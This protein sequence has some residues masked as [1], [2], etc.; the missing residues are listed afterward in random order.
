MTLKDFH[1][2]SA[3]FIL[4]HMPTAYT[5]TK[6]DDAKRTLEVVAIEVNRQEW[7]NELSEVDKNII[8]AM[9]NFDADKFKKCTGIEVRT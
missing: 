1:D 4:S 3:Y 8:K 6:W 9:P 5:T 7:Y 2:T